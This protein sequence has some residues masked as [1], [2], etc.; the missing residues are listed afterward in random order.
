MNIQDFSLGLCIITSYASFQLVLRSLCRAQMH[1]ETQDCRSDICR[2]IAAKNML[3]RL[4]H[5]ASR[6]TANTTK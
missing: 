1:V 6:D 3:V 5:S 4:K 2:S